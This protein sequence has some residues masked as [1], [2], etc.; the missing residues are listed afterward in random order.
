MLIIHPD[1]LWVP[2]YSPK[3]VTGLRQDSIAV[4]KGTGKGIG[5]SKTLRPA[6][7]RRKLRTEAQRTN[8]KTIPVERMQYNVKTRKPL[9]R[10]KERKQCVRR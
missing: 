3:Q 6:R 1:Y 2:E 5:R 4:P 8:L 7:R 9:I 10:C